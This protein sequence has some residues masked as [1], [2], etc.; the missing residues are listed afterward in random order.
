[1]L[2]INVI[3]IFREII[4]I[5]KLI[6]FTSHETQFGQLHNRAYPL[7]QPSHSILTL[8][9]LDIGIAPFLHWMTLL[10]CFSQS[11]TLAILLSVCITVFLLRLSQGLLLV[12]RSIVSRITPWRRLGYSEKNMVTSYN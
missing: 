7:S 10:L 6:S 1:M 9:C 2:H 12:Q 3:E 8:K 5:C 4:L 11:T